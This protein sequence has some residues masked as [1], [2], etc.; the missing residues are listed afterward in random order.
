MSRQAADLVEKL[1]ASYAHDIAVALA[2]RDIPQAKFHLRSLEYKL[3]SLDA[4]RADAEERELGQHTL[5]DSFPSD[6]GAGGAR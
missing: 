5:F 6:D 4:Q 2:D 3:K 1:K